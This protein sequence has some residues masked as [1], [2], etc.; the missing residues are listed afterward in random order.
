[1]AIKGGVPKPLSSPHPSDRGPDLEN[2]I[3]G[4]PRKATLP[5]KDPKVRDDVMVQ[6]NVKQPEPLMLKIE[7]LAAQEGLTKRQLIENMLRD[8]A[9]ARL[10]KM[11]IMEG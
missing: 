6:V 1:M 10:R 5:W 7:W 2:F 3:G 8:G 9:T 11:G 4:A